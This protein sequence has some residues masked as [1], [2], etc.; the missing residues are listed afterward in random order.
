[1]GSRRV[2]LLAV[3]IAVLSIAGILAAAFTPLLVRDHPLLLIVLE[4]RNRYLLLVSAK[5]GTAEFITVGV[6]RRLASD[7]FYY[8]LGRWY[9]ERAAQWVD[10]R[11]GGGARL[12]ESVE[13]WFRRVADVAVFLLPGALVCALAGLTGMRP[14]RFV[15][16]N[17]A[18]SLVVVVALRVLAAA[19]A[20]PIGEIVRFNDRNAGWLTVLFVVGTAAWL[21]WRRR[22]PAE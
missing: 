20:G 3:P 4:A 1:M 6:A 2:A 21:Y 13:Q 12:T 16:L 7:P 18:G 10:Q 15:S 5:L 17:L 11:L 22:N 9:G 8:L 14:A 19:A